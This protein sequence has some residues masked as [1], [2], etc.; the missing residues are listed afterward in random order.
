MFP[1]RRLAATGADSASSTSPSPEPR[2]VPGFGPARPQNRHA[3]SA[4]HLGPQDFQPVLLS[5]S[6]VYSAKAGAETGAT[7]QKSALERQRWACPVTRPPPP[8]RGRSRLQW[9]VPEGITAGRQGARVD[10]ASRSSAA[11]DTCR[12]VFALYQLSADPTLLDA[13]GV[14][15]LLEVG[16]S[17]DTN[18]QN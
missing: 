12:F 1:L 2:S 8:L 9:S 10:L 6:A 16:Y 14:I 17:G 7:P 15:A 13:F 18:A 5:C 3:R 4:L 11:T